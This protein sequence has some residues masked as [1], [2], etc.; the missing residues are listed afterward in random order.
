MR[1]GPLLLLSILLMFL[2]AGG[3]MFKFGGPLIH[4]LLPLAAISLVIHLLIGRKDTDSI[5]AGC[6]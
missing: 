1:V 3:F 2:W 5:P 4:L 6:P